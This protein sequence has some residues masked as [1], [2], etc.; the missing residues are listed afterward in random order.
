M[1]VDA[2]VHY[3]HLPNGINFAQLVRPATMRSMYWRFFGFPAN[4]DGQI[5]TREKIV[6]TLCCSEVAYNRNTTNLKGHLRV[7]HRGVLERVSSED[8]LLQK[9]VR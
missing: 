2:P 5:I 7:R 8:R 3:P 4:A 9:R 6:C 1:A